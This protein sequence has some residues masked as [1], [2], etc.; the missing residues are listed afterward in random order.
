LGLS[1]W[2]YIFYGLLVEV[3]VL[4]AL[5]PNLQRLRNGT[6]RFVGWRPGK[7]GKHDQGKV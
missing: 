6:E 2:E 5:R 7:G 4:I 3:L 1:P